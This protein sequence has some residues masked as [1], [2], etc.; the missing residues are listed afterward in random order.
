MLKLERRKT[1]Q[2]LL[3]DLIKVIKTVNK[4]ELYKTLFHPVLR[5]LKNWMF[6]GCIGAVLGLSMG[7]IG[8]IN[9]LY[10]GYQWAVLGLSMGCIG[11]VNGL[12][13]DIC[14]QKP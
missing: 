11:A 3:T 1:S 9:G 8:A 2:V 14:A 5:Q 6:T 4:R 13:M 7:C 10:W 12:S